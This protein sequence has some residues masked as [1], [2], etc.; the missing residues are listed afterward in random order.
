MPGEVDPTGHIKT[1]KTEREK[2]MEGMGEMS[3][4]IGGVMQAMQNKRQ[5]ALLDQIAGD[6]M[7]RQQ[8]QA[9]GR[10]PM[11]LDPNQGLMPG[12]G[13]A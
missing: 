5:M 4:G 13:M 8:N 3:E 11:I 10:N 1:N 6:M 9:I 2:A 7:M 12:Q